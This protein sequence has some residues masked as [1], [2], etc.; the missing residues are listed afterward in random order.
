MNRNTL[1]L[2]CDALMEYIVG[3]PVTV[4]FAHLGRDIDYTVAIQTSLFEF[5][6]DNEQGI[7]GPMYLTLNN[8]LL[9]DV[10]ELLRVLGKVVKE[11]RR[12]AE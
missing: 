7:M 2:V 12:D 9:Q 4:S 5:D 6:P 11:H 1:Q 8:Y 10:D 3:R